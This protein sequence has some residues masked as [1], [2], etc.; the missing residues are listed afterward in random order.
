MSQIFTMHFVHEFFALVVLNVCICLWVQLSYKGTSTP[1]EHTHKRQGSLARLCY[2]C[3]GN[4]LA[5]SCH[6]NE[7]VCHDCG[8]KGHI[9]KLS[10]KRG[11]KHIQRQLTT[12]EQSSQE[13][14]LLID[15][16]VLTI[17]PVRSTFVKPIQV[18]VT[19]D[20]HDL[21]MEL[22]TGSSM[23]P[24]SEIIYRKLWGNC[25]SPKLRASK[26]QLKTYTGDN[27]EFL[28]TLEVAVCYEGQYESLSLLAV[29][30]E[31]SSLFG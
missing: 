20:N 11:Q 17:H 25:D 31:R 3:G 15:L 30:E 6:C 16:K 12:L 7:M 8:M 19:V 13:T 24:I 29:K 9:V 27:I 22:D 21:V 1:V 18:P 23:S 2:R 26:V 5:P 10:Y 28:G 4:D 14:K